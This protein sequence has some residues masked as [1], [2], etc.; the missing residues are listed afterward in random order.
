MIS[1]LRNAFHISKSS[2]LLQNS[3][4]RF[5]LIA[6]L[7]F[8]FNYAEAS[9][10][11]V[12]VYS[13]S[14]KKNVK[15]VVVKPES[16]KRSKTDFPVVYLLHGFGGS[17]SNWITRVP[18]IDSLA[19]VYQLIIVCPDAAFSSWYFN[20]PVDSSFR[21]ETFT[22]EELPLFIDANYK[23][24]ATK[25]GRAITGL[26]MGGFGAYFLTLRH[27][28]TFGA[29]GSM[30]G[31]HDLTYIKNAYDVPKRLGDSIANGKYY[32]DWSVKTLFDK[33][34][35]KD[36]I[37]FILDC[38][39]KDFIFLMTKT[40]HEKMLQLKIPHDYIER[41]GMHDWRYWGNAVKYQLLFFR[42]WFN[43]NM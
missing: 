21:Y 26:S 37:A 19:N 32:V 8:L 5:L 6:L 23:T 43:R 3:S 22:A 16:Y 2:I 17:Y 30:S 31:A 36:S 7:L 27:T 10:D 40:L 14:M 38:G 11:T 12:E 4:M 1:N 25:K 35:P 18:V 29:C 15:C 39:I 9:V 41:P 33:Y 28:D 42:E 20:S 24:I 13:N 34:D